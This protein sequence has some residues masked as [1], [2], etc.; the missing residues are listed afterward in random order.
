MRRQEEMSGSAAVAA[1]SELN[2]SDWTPVKVFVAGIRVL[3]TAKRVLTVRTSD[4]I[5]GISGYGCN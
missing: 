5:R 4:Q 3:G 2:R 1:I